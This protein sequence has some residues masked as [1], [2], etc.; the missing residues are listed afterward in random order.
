MI[1]SATKAQNRPFR[2]ITARNHHHRRRRCFLHQLCVIDLAPGII[3]N[4]DPVIPAL[5]LEPAMPATVDVQQQAGQRSPLPPPA[6]HSALAPPGY[7]PGAW[8][9]RFHPGIAELNGMLG[10]P[11]LLKRLYLQIEIALAG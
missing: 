5:I 9:R 2:S 1:L 8:Q 7:P 10:L 3:Q 11:L 6:M 4:D